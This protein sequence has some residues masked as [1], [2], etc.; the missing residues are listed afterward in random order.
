[1]SCGAPAE[2]RRPARPPGRPTAPDSADATGPAAPRRGEPALARLRHPRVEEAHVGQRPHRL[3]LAGRRQRRQLN[4]ARLHVEPAR[5]LTVPPG[6]GQ[7]EAGGG[8]GAKAAEADHEPIGSGRDAHV[9]RR[10]PVE[11]GARGALQ[12]AGGLSGALRAQ[13]DAVDPHL[14]GHDGERER[15]RQVAARVPAQ[16]Q[17][18]AVD[19]ERTARPLGAE[20]QPTVDHAAQNRQWDRGWPPAAQRKAFGAQ[21]PTAPRAIEDQ[22]AAV[23][24]GGAA[25]GSP[26]RRRDGARTLPLSTTA[27]C[28]A[29]ARERARRPSAPAARTCR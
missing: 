3:E 21:V 24:R 27:R 26:S 9:D 5:P 12:R 15:C 23:G 28:R 13:R 4:A 6:R 10:Q 19:A 2:S 14:A 17:R 29:A 22:P 8:V 11:R 25:R 18:A 16:D 20:V 7:R 1:M